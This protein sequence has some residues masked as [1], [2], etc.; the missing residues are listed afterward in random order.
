M[1]HSVFSIVNYKT[2]ET[3]LQGRKR[4]IYALVIVCV[5]LQAG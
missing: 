4:V 1:K 5:V 3:K 2:E